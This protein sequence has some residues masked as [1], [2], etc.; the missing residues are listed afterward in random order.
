MGA[1]VLVGHRY[2]P[3]LAVR[4]ALGDLGARDFGF[5]AI[6]SALA[7]RA[8]ALGIRVIATN[9]SGKPF[10]V[11]GVERAKSLPA[12][13][14]ESDHVV[15]AAPA[16][17]ETHHLVDA[18]LLSHAKPGLH[19]INIARGSLVDEQALIAALDAGQLERATL[20]VS[21]IEPAPANHPFYSH[22]K[23][24]LS[25]H[26]SPSTGICGAT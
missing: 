7:I 4:S 14:A 21:Q 25:P 19:L 23:V 12:L 3:G 11:P 10:Y 5:G 16:T 24:R 26:V 1:F 20:D 18:Q 15:V 13:F 8:Q 6:G 17:A 9:H 2:L 22:P